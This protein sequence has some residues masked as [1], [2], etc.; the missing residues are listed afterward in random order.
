MVGRTIQAMMSGSAVAHLMD[1]NFPGNVRELENLVEQAAALAEADEL[2]PEDFP[3]RPQAPVAHRTR[4][5]GAIVYGRG[6]VARVHHERHFPGVDIPEPAS[7][8]LA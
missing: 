1:Y 2:M 7:Q 5:E 3:L 4:F 6:G 8:I